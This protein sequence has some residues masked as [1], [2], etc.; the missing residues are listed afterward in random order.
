M[1]ALARAQILP[2]PGHRSSAVFATARL[3]FYDFARSVPV[4]IGFSSWR[5]FSLPKLIGEFPDT[6]LALGVVHP[7]LFYRVVH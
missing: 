7:L 4:V 5:S 6:Q 2:P 1:K 3:A